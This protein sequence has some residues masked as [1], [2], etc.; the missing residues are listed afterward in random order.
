MDDL[1]FLEQQFRQEGAVLARHSRNQRDPRRHL[2]ISPVR[3]R[4]S[5]SC[6][7]VPSRDKSKWAGLNPARPKRLKFAGNKT[8]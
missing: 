4:R 7:T 3:N 6:Y 1:T 5:S 8:A 2:N